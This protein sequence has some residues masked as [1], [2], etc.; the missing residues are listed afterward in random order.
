MPP[1]RFY[2]HGKHRTQCWCVQHS[3]LPEATTS[4]LHEMTQANQRMHACPIRRSIF[5]GQSSHCQR[6]PADRRIWSGNL[7]ECCKATHVLQHY[8]PGHP[9]WKGHG[10]CSD[11]MQALTCQSWGACSTTCCSMLTGYRMCRAY[12]CSPMPW[13]W[14]QAQTAC[15]PCHLQGCYLHTG[16]C[17]R[18]QVQKCE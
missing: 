9:A 3:T 18:Q 14:H 16:F 11:K 10:P 5:W 8:E 1:A 4:K 13:P 2:H 17:C 7:P 6:T 15:I 12:W